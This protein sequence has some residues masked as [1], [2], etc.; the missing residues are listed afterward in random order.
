MEECVGVTLNLGSYVLTKEIRFDFS[1]VGHVFSTYSGNWYSR[2]SAEFRVK[3]AK[4]VNLT[5]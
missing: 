4:I 3:S 2:Y 5:L 1:Q